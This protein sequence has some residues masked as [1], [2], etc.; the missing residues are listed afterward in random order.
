[1]PP[2]KVGDA[3]SIIPA[4]NECVQFADSVLD[5]YID[6]NSEL[7]PHLWASS[8]IFDHPKTTN[9]PESF[10]SHV[11]KQFYIPHPHLHQVIAVLLE[12]QTENTIKINSISKN[13]PNAQRKKTIKKKKSLCK[14]HRII[15]KKRTLANYNTYNVWV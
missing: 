9:G 2:A 6:E 4:D 15:M 12:I 7:S 10:Y 11:N 14:K 8:P 3:L 1:L 5:T 13:F